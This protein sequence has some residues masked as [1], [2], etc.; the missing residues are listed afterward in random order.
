MPKNNR[1]E[2]MLEFM[3]KNYG[4]IVAIFTG[5]AFM[6]TFVLRFMKYLKSEVYFSYYGLQHGLFSTGELNILY[7]FSFSVLTL[8]CLCASVICCMQL[9]FIKKLK[10]KIR[11]IIFDIFLIILSNV[12]FILSIASEYRNLLLNSVILSVFE[13]AFILLNIKLEGKKE[14]KEFN[15][16][17]FFNIFKVLPFYVMLLV[18]TFMLKYDIDISK[19][20]TYQIIN[21]NKAIVYTTNDYYLV[22]DCEIKGD[23]LLLYKGRQTK[24]S[25]D[26]VK[27]E[28]KK[29]SKVDFVSDEDP[30]Q[31]VSGS[32]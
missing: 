28:L 26:N 10:L 1:V 6:L 17:D 7:D 15:L 4:W 12:F 22:L 3:Q 5:T 24:I 19:N 23:G 13:Y 16:H 20:K 27:S 32:K 14:A 9:C 30:K 25:T 2:K 18:I 31:I 8:F 29:F 11:T 21:D